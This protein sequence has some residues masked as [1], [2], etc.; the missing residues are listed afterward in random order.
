MHRVGEAVITF[1]AF[2]H[3]AT[4]ADIGHVLGWHHANICQA[5][6]WL[7]DE[8]SSYILEWDLFEMARE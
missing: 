5:P 2:V 1:P 6:S 4:A 8:S 7:G 3:A